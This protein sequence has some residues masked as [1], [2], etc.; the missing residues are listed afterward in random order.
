MRAI[1]SFKRSAMRVRLLNHFSRK[2]EALP[3]PAMNAPDPPKQITAS[4]LGV[5]PGHD[6]PM[7][8]ACN[9]AN[10]RK[11][12]LTESLQSLKIVS[13]FKGHDYL[14]A[15]AQSAV[16]RIDPG[17]PGKALRRHPHATQGFVK[18]MSKPALTRMKLRHRTQGR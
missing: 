4:L 1:V 11:T 10:S 2:L 18:W 7:S 5:R 14:A 15:A 3:V 13:A 12:A 9:P 17:Q 16:L 8:V 6:M